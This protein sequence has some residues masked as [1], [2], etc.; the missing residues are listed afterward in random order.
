MNF[1]YTVVADFA[2]IMAVAAAVS[3]IFNKL[4]Q[5]LILGYLVAGIIIGPYSPPFSLVSRLDVLN[6]VAELGMI[7]LMFGIGMEFPLSRL[8]TV[9]LRVYI[10]ISAIEISLMFLVS[11][12]AG[13]ML[14][15]PLFDSVFLG[16]ALAS[17]ST[18][19]IMKVLRDMGKLQDV[20]ATVMAGVL[21]A[22]DLIVILI[23]AI[24]TS[25]VSADF[26]R[27]PELAWTVGKAAVFLIGTVVLGILIIPRIIDWIGHP[28]LKQDERTEHSE[29]LMLFALGLCFGWAI[30]SS[31]AGLSVAIGAFLIGVLVAASRSASRIAT[32]TF[33]IKDMFGAIFFVSMGALIDISQFRTFLIPGLAVTAM[34]FLGKVVG[35]GLGTRIFRYDLSTSLKVGLGMGQIGE[36]AFIVMKVGVDL[37]VISSFLFPT[38][39]LAVALTAFLTPYTIRLSY[40]LHPSQNGA[41]A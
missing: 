23:L 3:L 2:V 7:L 36:F 6:A 19:I 21:V 4:K 13:W 1:S 14:R 39:G 34:M 28:D 18:V 20:S 27:L 31:A 26:M 10:G 5:P 35:C 29:V 17:S 30:L 32:L 40:K 16:A 9:G 15:W 41:Q 37:G 8:R 12:A 24:I 11:F 25:I 33:S 22:E 38:V